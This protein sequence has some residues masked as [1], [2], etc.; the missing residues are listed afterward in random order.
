MAI[1]VKF[2][3]A[4]APLPLR[5]I[6]A[7]R[8]GNRIRELPIN[9]VRFKDTLTNG[10]EISFEVHRNLCLDHNG[11]VD[12]PFWRRITDFKLAYC[13]EFDRWYELHIE[14]N[15]SDETMKVV[16]AVSLGE[17]ELS[18]INLYEFEANTEDD[19]ARDD[20]EPTILYN[21][22]NPEASLIDR[23]LKKAPHYRVAHVDES[24]AD[25][26]RTFD[27]DGKSIRD[28]FD[29]VAKEIGCLF[30]FDCVKADD[31]KVDR[32]VSVYDLE[33]YC[34]SCGYRGDFT[35]QCEKCGSTAIRPGYGKDT[36]IFV[37][38]DNLANSI[39]Y[40]TDVDSVKNCFRLEAGDDL[41]TATVINC[42]PNG[43]QYIWFFSDEMMEDMS[44]ELRDKIADYNEMYDEYQNTYSYSPPSDLVT[45]YN[46]IVSKYSSM[47]EDLSP[48]AVPIIGYPAL[49][50]TQYDTIDLQLYLN[51]SLMPNVEITTTDAAAEAAK[52]TVGNLSPIA[53]AKLSTC[54]AETAA[55]AVL[56]MAKCLVRSTF[57]LK[58][59]SSSYNAGTHVWTGNF[60]VTNYGDEN[61][62]ATSDTVSIL[63]NE[64]IERYVKQKLDRAMKKESDDVTDISA[65][66]DLE[67]SQFQIE[68]RKYSLQ[69]LLAF[70][71]ACQA[72]LDILIQNGAGDRDAQASALVDLYTELYLPYR[73]KAEDIETE[74]AIRTQEIAVVAGVYDENGGILIDGMQS[75][76]ESKRN[77]I[78]EALNFEDYLG[79]ELW[80]EFAS[81]RREDT[82]E[83]SNYISD[84]LDN[85]QLFAM[86]EQFIA[87]AQK[88]IYRSSTL[89]HTISAT[90]KNLLSMHEFAPVVNDFSV[91]NW[92]RIK[93]D[94]NVYRLR[95]ED[96]ELDYDS[97][98]LSSVNFTD[99]KYGHN[100]A[101]D[102]GSLLDSVRSMQTSYGAVM[103]Q[104]E[105]G[106]KSYS[107]MNNWSSEGFSLTTKIVGGA[108][109]QEFIMDSTGVTG[110]ELIQETEGYSD[111]QIKII[112]N[113]IYV[114]DDGWT[115]VK[116]GLGKF[117]FW[118]PETQQ[119]ET[120]FGV[121][122][123]TVVSPIIL[124]QNVGIY[125]ESGDVKIDEN[126]ITIIADE[127]N[128]E[129]VF[130][131]LRRGSGGS[132][133][134]ILSIDANGNLVLSSYAPKSE[135]I[136]TVDTEYAVGD[137][138]ETAPTTGWSSETPSWTPGKYIWQRIKKTDGNNNETY[139][140]P[141]C[142][143]G[144]SG[145]D[146][147][148]TAVVN[149][150]KRSS[151]A[152]SIDWT[153]TLTYTFA[154]HSLNSVPTGWST[155][156]PSGT[157]PIYI[158]AATASS[159]SATDTIAYTEWTSPVVF[160]P[161]DNSIVSLDDEY[162]LSTSATEPSGGTWVDECPEW[163]N[164]TVIW[165]RTKITFNN[166][167]I[168]YTD[169]I[170]ASS[171]NNTYESIV[172]VQKSADSIRTD[173]IN[174]Y[175]TQSAMASRDD[176]LMTSIREGNIHT[177]IEQTANGV[178]E[179]Y[180]FSESIS[181]LDSQYQA[182]SS[183]VTSINGEIRRG[184][185]TD[186]DSGETA[187]GIAISQSF[188]TT[189]STQRINNEV[190][191]EFDGEQMQ[192]LGIY[193]STGWQFWLN[194]HKVG[195][196]DSTDGML[197]VTS[198]V[199]E[200]SLQLGDWSMVGAG[201]FGL[202][203]IG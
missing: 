141:V 25:V 103:R 183:S 10:S 26:Q 117:S 155:S 99:V 74:I 147:I 120:R 39:V 24:V 11:N 189:G 30:Q 13:P 9:E 47:N 79:E 193:T 29:E 12:D 89:Q 77:E 173:L 113:G 19:I 23:M 100:S 174:N 90:L 110:R 49:M 98:A 83:N 192:S 71:D 43:S 201:G 138:D 35:S 41:M 27:F 62:T 158:T 185:I 61:D 175:V 31:G 136:K 40:S 44:D 65:L 18:Q 198:E 37:S 111:E 17:A 167:S 88:E 85:A 22:D 53:V 102:I 36:T 122:A 107:R 86:A 200:N 184:Y 76:I 101:S 134:S 57:Q 164:G 7:T 203:Y 171:I 124:S 190:Y 87:V 15:E 63:I 82:F 133:S 14:V 116:A 58:V 60:T 150:F 50:T 146:G 91:G 95:L 97:W 118:N 115:T 186:P 159:S 70:R 194:G 172:E 132:T 169:P 69:R 114:T 127:S 140:N 148:N 33:N 196:F 139:S 129:T 125:N 163:I 68:L 5:L 84:G 6:L 38:K 142:I 8:A 166:G 72:S 153:D 109:N 178:V 128:N 135:T 54:T 162:Y 66:F 48:I 130:Q 104:A 45:Q 32:T 46:N 157:Y 149:L 28:A 105:K 96:Y 56:G 75:L 156:V 73:Q 197:H 195:W 112:S 121:I 145:A 51:S 168:S 126:G 20:Y 59:N 94:N 4:G 152:V 1:K 131:I 202:R 81:Y 42:N 137:D 34:T 180:H 177:I 161:G 64:D 92:I 108:D 52:L 182:L 188:V 93:V 179:G 3:S 80:H 143:Q 21:S 170:P 78:R 2:D 123:D 154:T 151:S 187:I 176:D 181:T 191:E 144:A 67:R 165:Q 106:E 16:N 119:Y 160:T 55:N 199:A